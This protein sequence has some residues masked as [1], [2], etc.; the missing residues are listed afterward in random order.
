MNTQEQYKNYVIN[1]IDNVKKGFDM[2]LP[3]L[4]I[5]NLSEHELNE[6]KHNVEHHDD[7]KFSNEE[8]L[9]YAEY[10]YGNKT[11]VAKKN[12]KIAVKIHK[13]RNSHH[14]EYWEAKNL[15]MPPIAIIEMVLDWYSFSLDK[16]DN[17]E[18]FDF[19]EKNKHKLSPQI[20]ASV[21]QVLQLIKKLN[22]PKN[23]K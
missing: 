22:K 7:S 15:A 11:E 13:E 2:L 12:F 8:F 9:P 5:F 14:P 19:Y 10:F 4:T 21:E 3:Y 6:L 17:N 23:K 20:N 18:I 16:N 1:H